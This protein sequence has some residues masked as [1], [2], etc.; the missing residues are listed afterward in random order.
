MIKFLVITF[1]LLLASAMAGPMLKGADED[2]SDRAQPLLQAA[3]N[4]LPDFFHLSP[5]ARTRAPDWT[6]K[7]NS[8]LGHQLPRIG[9]ARTRAPDWTTKINSDLGRQLPRIG[10]PR[11]Q[12]PGPRLD[13]KN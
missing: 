13:N 3:R 8:D 5:G 6:T 11:C 12:D 10:V 1:W 7:I 2:H 4:Q 9:G